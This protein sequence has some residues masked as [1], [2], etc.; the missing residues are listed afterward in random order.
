[1]KSKQ[2]ESY[3][4]RRCHICFAQGAGGNKNHDKVVGDNTKF[5]MEKVDTIWRDIETDLFT[6]RAS[7]SPTYNMS[8]RRLAKE[9]LGKI[10][11]ILNATN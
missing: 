3:I 8:A 4:Y 7:I 6:I 10:R 9:L 2:L 5:I 11:R 1:M